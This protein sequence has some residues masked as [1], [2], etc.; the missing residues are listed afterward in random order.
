MNEEFRRQVYDNMNLKETDELV[1]IWRAND[2]L[3]WSDEAFE[4]IAEILRDRAVDLASQVQLPS[5]KTAGEESEDDG[6]TTEELRIIDDVNPPE[7]YD[8]FEVLKLEKWIEWAIRAVVV[9]TI[10]Y[11]LIR[12]PSFISMVG[13]YFPQ[14]PTSVFVYAIALGIMGLNAVIGI[15]IYYFILRTLAQILSILMEME[16]NSRKA[17]Q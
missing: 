6:L 7:F 13:A 8:P 2:H 3:E 10:A 15:V 14:S 4:V 9:M 11:N 1:E 5:Q 16:F 12:Y 17:K